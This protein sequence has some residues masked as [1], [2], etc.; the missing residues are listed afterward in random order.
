MKLDQLVSYIA[1]QPWAVTDARWTGMESLIS[2]V[3]NGERL[4]ETEVRERLAAYQYD[5]ATPQR[6]TATRQGAIG[7][8]PITADIVPR[9]SALAEMFGLVT[10]CA[11]LCQSIRAFAADPNVSTI[12]LDVYSGG[13]SVIGGHEVFQELQRAKAGGTKVVAHGQFIGSLAYWISAAADE[14]VGS[15]SG[16]FG[17]IGVKTAHIDL[18]GALEMAGVKVTLIAAGRH[19]GEDDQRLPFTKEAEANLRQRAEAYYDLFVKDVAEGR[20]VTVAQVRAGY[21]EGRMLGARDAKREG[22]IDRIESLPETI[23]RLMGRK[24]SGRGAAASVIEPPM[25]ASE[26]EPEEEPPVSAPPPVIAAAE[27]PAPSP[28]A[29]DLAAER[30]ALELLELS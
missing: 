3:M 1:G 23:E 17:S 6:P 9:A 15:E 14:I 20:G 10:S 7:V 5:E 25:E 8:V 21:G 30:R 19:K 26:R 12:L 11:R 13:G 24:R 29:P 22:L 27:P 4:S 16:E 28:A 2:A 18:S